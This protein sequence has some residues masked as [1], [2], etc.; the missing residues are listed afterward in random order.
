MSKFSKIIFAS[1]LSTLILA[2]LINIYVYWG[3]ILTV[4]FL[5]VSNMMLRKWVDN[6]TKYR[7]SL[8]HEE[9][10]LR[11]IYSY[12]GFPI[13]ILFP[14]KFKE[15]RKYSYY[16]RKLK[17]LEEMEKFYTERSFPITDEMKEELI[18]CNRYLKLKRIKHKQEKV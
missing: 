10:K 5:Q 12:F 2:W 7:D 15:I 18:N 1:Y 16:E 9:E 6:K 14:K 13:T 17:E 11:L 8:S 4:L 3:I